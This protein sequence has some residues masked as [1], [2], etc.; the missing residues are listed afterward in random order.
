[1][2]WL[3]DWDLHAA[4]TALKSALEINPNHATAH[5]SRGIFLG[6]TRGQ[7][8]EALAEMRHVKIIDPLSPMPDSSIGWIL[9]W[10]RQF[11]ESKQQFSKILEAKEDLTSAWQGRG[12]ADLEMKEFDDALGALHKALAISG[13]PSSQGLLGLA[14]GRSGNSD[15]ARRKLADLL[16]KSKQESVPSLAIAQIYLGL[17]DAEECLG[18]LVKAV[19]ERDPQIFWIKAAPLYDPLRSDPRLA[20]LQKKIGLA[21]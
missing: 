21:S 12:L 16:D 20:V 11:A 7:F 13:D 4:E 14:Y 18:W 2:H 3:F 15:E 5:W 19:E 10:G 6:L 9:Y 1:V 8:N 17:D